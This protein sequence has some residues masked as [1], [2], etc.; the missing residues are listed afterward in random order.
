MCTTKKWRNT[1]LSAL[2]I[3]I[4]DAYKLATKVFVLSKPPKTR[5][6]DIVTAFLFVC[7]NISD[8][9]T[10]RT[11]SGKRQ[12]FCV[13]INTQRER[14]REQ[15]GTDNK[16]ILQNPPEENRS[17][18][19]PKQKRQVSVLAGCGGS[20]F[21]TKRKRGCFSFTIDICFNHTP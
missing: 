12:R 5:A 20:R 3:S 2:I 4:T 19:G 9:P 10:A 6:K 16:R 21:F 15:F 8:G 7:L 18:E 14:E 1:F 17:S 13:A 11:N